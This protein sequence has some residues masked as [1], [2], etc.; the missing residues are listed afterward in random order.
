[1]AIVVAALIVFIFYGV[2][3]EYYGVREVGNELCPKIPGS[4]NLGR[5]ARRNRR[6]A[7]L[8]RVDFKE[9]L[10]LDFPHFFRPLFRPKIWPSP[11]GSAAET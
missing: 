6:L 7:Y 9:T 1:M 3:K 11:E 10:F 2:K 5:F 8:Q 4:S